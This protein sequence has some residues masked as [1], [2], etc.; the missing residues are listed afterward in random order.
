MKKLFIAIV[1][2]CCAIIVSGQ[3]I[4]KTVQWRLNPILNAVE[5]SGTE[6]EALIVA[7]EKFQKNELT[8]RTSDNP[9]ENGEKELNSKRYLSEVQNI[10]GKERFDIWRK[11]LREKHNSPNNVGGKER[12]VK[13]TANAAY[14]IFVEDMFARD[15]YVYVDKKSRHYYMHLNDKQKIG[16]YKSPDLVNWV[17][18]ETT[19][20]AP[21]D[22]WGTKDFWAPDT[23]YYKDKYYV[24]ASFSNPETGMKGTSALVSKWLEGPY[25]PLVN[26]PI[27]PE[28][29]RCLDGLLYVDET[30]QPW[31]LFCQ[32][33]HSVPDGSG[34]IYAQKLSSDLKTAIEEPILLFKASEAPWA[35]TITHN[36]IRGYVTD[37][38]FIYRARNG[39]LLLLWS[40]FAKAPSRYV[41][42]V[43]R[44]SNG[45]LDGKWIQDEKPLNT[46]VD[47]GGHAM[48]FTDLND[49]LRIAYHAPN[50]NARPKFYWLDDDN[51]KLKI[52]TIE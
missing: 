25:K 10:L 16:L 47:G 17:R 24:F 22:F 4:S 15:P 49:Q 30:D 7:I 3:E 6:K 13:R 45:K 1:F 35:G 12:E 19:F 8:L 50:K 34:R 36:G 14:P 52:R 29:W 42:G 31:L 2:A 9:N 28:D 20:E 27:T 18:V 32:A 23:Y 11:S 5:V 33:F 44:S 39:E 41:I 51:G 46:E 21:H 40:S 26:K 37:S 38:P 48:I 43:A